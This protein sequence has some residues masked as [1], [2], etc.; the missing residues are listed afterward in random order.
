MPP[1]MSVLSLATGALAVGRAAVAV[2]L[3]L[4]VALPAV[5]GAQCDGSSD[6][7]A[8]RSAWY[9]FTRIVVEPLDASMPAA[10]LTIHGG[11]D[12]SVGFT[13]VPKHGSAGRIIVVDGRAML[14]REVQHEAG[15]EIDALDGPVLMA[16][17]V[18]TLLDQ[19]FP[20]GPNSVRTV[21]RVQVEQKTR[22]IRIATAS[23]DARFEAP[24]TLSGTVRRRAEHVEYDL[25][26][27]AGTAD[28]PYALHAR[29]RW[30][31]EPKPT[32]L[33]DDMPLDGWKV[34]WLG[35]M[36][37]TS[38]DGTTFDYAAQPASSRWKDVAALRRWI[39]EEP[40]RRASR[41][42]PVDAANPG[43]PQSIAYEAF[44]TDKKGAR[45]LLGAAV[46]DYKPGSDVLAEETR[47]HAI[48]KTLSCSAGSG[49]T[50]TTATC[51]ASCWVAERSGSASSRVQRA[52]SL[53]RSSSWTTSCSTAKTRRTGPSTTRGSSRA[54]C[55]DSVLDGA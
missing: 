34:H 44:L 24:W 45:S 8:S 2:T 47:D 21:H 52:R 19:A 29:G 14:M 37:T 41:R 55:C 7:C 4:L 18:V 26:F 12:L 27:S 10:T 51:S 1:E 32:S 38:A 23:A 16:H 53:R 39:S 28:A 20:A 54:A 48:R 50:G 17:L 13:R 6:I 46:R 40:A 49:A 5:G 3:G 25:R 35:P 11:Q 42:T 31:K 33:D 43:S 36:T 9:E 15:Y 30:Q 22:A